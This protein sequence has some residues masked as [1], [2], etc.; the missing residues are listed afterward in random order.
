MTLHTQPGFFPL[1]RSLE[2]VHNDLT[3]ELTRLKAEQPERYPSAAALF[4]KH[5]S[6]QTEVPAA[7]ILLQEMVTLTKPLAAPASTAL[8]D[9]FA[10]EAGAH[11]EPEP[12][13]PDPQHEAP[14]VTPHQTQA[15]DQPG[16]G[17]SE[18]ALDED[19]ADAEDVLQT[20]QAPDA[21]PPASLTVHWPGETL[22]SGLISQLAETLGHAETLSLVIT[23]V[24]DHL[25]ITVQ[26][27][28]I[29]NEQAATALPL[30]VK[31]TPAA[32][33]SDLAVALSGYQEG[34]QVARELASGYAQQIKDAAERSRQKTAKTA[35]RAS[36]TTSATGSVHVEVSPKDAM[37]VLSDAGGNTYPVAHMVKATLSPGGYT[38]TADAPG[39]TSQQQ[40]VTVRPSKTEK[41]AMVLLREGQTGMF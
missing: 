31:G 33:D 35:A 16:K 26:P 18:D 15:A 21:A 25:L 41:L 32:L 8:L 5:A 7:E 13:I 38:L 34:R 11:A 29:T 24:N 4:K 6:A 3:T 23:R 14:V 30:Q 39:Y 40:S 27:K 22:G 1:P 20:S 2:Q 36:P 12:L 17:D 28:A 9:L 10:P 19:P 37:L